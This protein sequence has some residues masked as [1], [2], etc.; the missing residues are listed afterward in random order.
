MFKF[1][2]GKWFDGSFDH[3]CKQER[4]SATVVKMFDKLT[5]M[6]QLLKRKRRE[7]TQNVT[8]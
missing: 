1:S 4:V 8:K 3:N 7:L 5:H 2:D 6:W